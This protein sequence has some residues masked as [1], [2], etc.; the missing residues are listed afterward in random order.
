MRNNDALV[1]VLVMPVLTQYYMY[2]TTNF[3][4]ENSND[5]FFKG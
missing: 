4:I 5:L 2:I 3:E 1:P